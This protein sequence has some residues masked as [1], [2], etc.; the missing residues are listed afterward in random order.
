MHEHKPS[1]RAGVVSD[2]SVLA[3]GH[4][5]DSHSDDLI[6]IVPLPF[7]HL[8]FAHMV[9][10]HHFSDACWFFRASTR[11]GRLGPPAGRV[12][13]GGSPMPASVDASRRA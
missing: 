13:E 12:T 9:L 8:A 2:Q 1:G 10:R 6:T 7:R 5:A 11:S 4:H 3:V